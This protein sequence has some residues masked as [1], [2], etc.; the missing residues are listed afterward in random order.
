MSRQEIEQK[1]LPNQS[2]IGDTTLKISM[3]VPGYV[4]DA[5]K[6]YI[7]L[8]RQKEVQEI[9]ILAPYFSDD[10]I[11]R[12]LV[13]AANRL[14]KKMHGE[15]LKEIKL[16]HPNFD[17]TQIKHKVR[18]ELSKSKKIHVVF[19]KKQENAIIAEVS[20]Y[21]AHYLRNNVIV[22]TLQFSAVQG[23]IKYEMLHAKQMVVVLGNEEK[24]WKKYVKFG[25][26]YNPAGR[27]HNM[28]ELNTI[29]YSGNWD[30]SD[31][32]SEQDNEVK[33][34]LDDVMRHVVKNYA[35]PFPWGQSNYKISM[36][37]KIIMKLA[38]ILFF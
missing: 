36:I 34:Y 8:L 37:E 9:F 12:A 24:K 23:N 21:Y 18:E 13:F 33:K 30:Q 35:E 31:D 16:H 38:Q 1:F 3:N 10:K 26:S 29:A 4:Q 15:K 27:A 7:W 28:W 2:N 6:D 19:P 25:G 22:E 14:E 11:A 17:S 5:Q 20:K 32:S